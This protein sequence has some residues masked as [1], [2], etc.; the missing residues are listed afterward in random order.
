MII[1]AHVT[2]VQSIVSAYIYAM[3]STSHFIILSLS[4]SLSFTLSI[5]ADPLRKKFHSESEMSPA[6]LIIS[7]HNIK[8]KTILCS[9]NRPLREREREI[10]FNHQFNHHH[11]YIRHYLAT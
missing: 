3:Y 9:S 11:K 8:E 7:T 5:P 4:F 1:N 6:C 10:Q 2:T